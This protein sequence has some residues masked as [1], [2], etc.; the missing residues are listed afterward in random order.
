[1]ASK[2]EVPS[3]VGAIKEEEQRRKRTKVFGR[4]IEV[5]PS[6][7]ATWREGPFP[8]FSD[9]QIKEYSKPKLAGA[10]SRLERGLRFFRSNKIVSM[11]SHQEGDVLWIRGYVQRSYGTEQRPA[12]IN[13]L[14]NI[15]VGAHCTC[16]V[17]KSG[18]CGHAIALLYNLEHNTKN[19][20][21]KLFHSCTSL[22]QRWHRK[23]K[24]RKT[25]L[26]PIYSYK[27]TNAVT[28]KNRKN[29]QRNIPEKV[30]KIADKLTTK[31]VE[32]HFLQ[33]LSASG[34]SQVR[35]GGLYTLLSDR[36][37]THSSLDHTY[38]GQHSAAGPSLPNTGS[39]DHASYTSQRDITAPGPSATVFDGSHE[40][41]IKYYD[42]RQ[43]TP[44]WSQL[45]EGKVTA[46][47]V[48][49]LI[50][51]SGSLKFSSQWNVVHGVCEAVSRKPFRNFERGIAYENVAR[52]KFVEDSGIEVNECGIY[53]R[54][55]IGASP[56]G[57]IKT[58][59]CDWLLEIKTRAEKCSGPLK[60]IEKYMYLQTQLQMFCTGRKYCLL[61]S[62]HPE[63][64]YAHYFV[65]C[66]DNGLVDV[67]VKCLMSILSKTPLEAK[68]EAEL[69]Q[70]EALWRKCEGTVPSFQS[71]GGLRR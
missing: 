62:Y 30:S 33:T 19:G 5:L 21:F 2:D 63:T 17:G 1:M 44:E 46:S 45:R 32:L 3:L 26:K 8:S 47:K 36:Y 23:G 25:M 66:Y 34:E 10:R 28:N 51:L 57:L 22:P 38:T 64:L 52:Q 68:W 20:T 37:I 24:A 4:E 14:N 9:K 16:K 53:F 69:P 42:V 61:M 12:Y 15:A 35:R 56:D 18:L 27:V 50:G 54:G 41:E 31:E 58:E 13:F 59:D 48:G 49:D 70:Y 60:T 55:D 29:K 40:S 6:K 65:I 43:G 39:T 71:L 11:R 7:T 67:V